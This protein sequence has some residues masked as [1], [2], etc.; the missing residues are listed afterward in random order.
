MNV[1][2]ADS[3]LRMKSAA[4]SQS[5]DSRAN[6]TTWPS[7]PATCS[8]RCPHGRSSGPDRI[9]APAESLGFRVDVVHQDQEL[10]PESH[11]GSR[12]R[13]ARARKVSK[14]ANFRLAVA[15]PRSRGRRT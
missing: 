14:R 8:V 5:G 3:T 12:P 15:T 6:S 1:E 4:I 10:G 11:S 2:P 7:G 9:S 13:S